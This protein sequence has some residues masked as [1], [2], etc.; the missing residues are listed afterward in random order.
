MKL[1]DLGVALVVLLVAAFIWWRNRRANNR[2]S[3]E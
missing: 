2:A 3:A 1:F